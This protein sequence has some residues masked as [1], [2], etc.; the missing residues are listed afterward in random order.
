MY[1]KVVVEDYPGGVIFDD[2]GD[3]LRFSK[4]TRECGGIA[5]TRP[6]SMT[7]EQF[8]KMEEATL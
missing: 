7:Q 3:A 2:K 6:T 1:W 4:D 8:E 5:Y